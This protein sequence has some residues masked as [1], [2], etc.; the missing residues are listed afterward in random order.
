MRDIF[1]MCET[2]SSIIPPDKY[3]Q[4]IDQARAML[5]TL[6][7]EEFR[8]LMEA[9]DREFLDQAFS[10]M[11]ASEGSIWLADPGSQELVMAVNSGPDAAALELNTRQPDTEG[12]LGK[13]YQEDAPYADQGIFRDK[14]ESHM[15]DEALH[16]HT[17]HIAGYPLHVLGCKIG[18]LSIV[19]VVGEHAKLPETWGFPENHGEVFK[20]LHTGLAAIVEN[21]LIRRICN[22]V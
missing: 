18:V 13:V 6:T 19:Q 1:S 22:Q 10:M 4:W 8:A 2:S 21:R 11:M 9:G 12:I 16:Q 15:V 17:L 14:Y 20:I 3:S 7:A 5:K